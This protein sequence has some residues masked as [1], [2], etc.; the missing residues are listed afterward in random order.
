MRVTRVLIE[1][2]YK[3]FK[4]IVIIGWGFNGL[5]NH[6]ANKR[7]YPKTRKQSKHPLILSNIPYQGGGDY[8]GIYDI[9][10]KRGF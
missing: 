1:R 2:E 10:L 5:N 6:I 9:G 4:G 3:G 8:R 7:V